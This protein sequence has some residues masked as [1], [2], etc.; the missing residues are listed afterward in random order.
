MRNA[1]LESLWRDEHNRRLDGLV[2]IANP[3]LRGA[4]TVACR[5]VNISAIAFR[6]LLDSA[7]LTGARRYD[8][9]VEKFL[10]LDH[11]NFAVSPHPSGSKN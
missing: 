4:I 2:A 10:A 8:C 5:D 3:D 11:R 1:C 9:S 6:Q 7:D